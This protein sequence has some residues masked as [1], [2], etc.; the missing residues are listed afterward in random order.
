ADIGHACHEYG[1]FYV[2]RH[3]VDER[4]VL[5]LE[6]VSRQFFR[7]DLTTKLEIEMSRGGRAWRGD[8]PVGGGLTSGAPEMKRVIYFGAEIDED[9]PLVKSG[10]P[11]HG[12]NLF[13]ASIPQLRPIVL[14]YMS[15]MTRLGHSLMRGIALSLGLEQSYFAD[16]YTADPLIL[17]R[18]FNY[19]A[20]Q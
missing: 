17:F 6:Q 3:D 11:L 12:R 20:G 7:L 14:D 16:R 13:P 2:T 5:Q 15:A 8:F 9:H 1:F 19:P 4:L 10:A 18:V